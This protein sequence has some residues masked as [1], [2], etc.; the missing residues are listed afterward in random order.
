RRKCTTAPVKYTGE[1]NVA[2]GDRSTF[3]VEAVRKRELIAARRERGRP[4]PRAGDVP[5]RF[6]DGNVRFAERSC[7]LQNPWP[8]GR[9]ADAAATAQVDGSGVDADRARVV[10][11]G[12]H[13]AD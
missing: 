3:E 12:I 5:C 9:A 13:L 4:E 1:S 8:V 2:A 10:D 6:A 7:E 11:E